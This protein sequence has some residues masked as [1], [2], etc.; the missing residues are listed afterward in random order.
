MPF[1]RH[2]THPGLFPIKLLWRILTYSKPENTFL[3]K[4]TNVVK[5]TIE[6]AETFQCIRVLS[7]FLIDNKFHQ[8]HGQTSGIS[9]GIAPQQF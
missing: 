9:Q 2:L 6:I 3:N 1:K 5:Y 8:T 7:S 4:T